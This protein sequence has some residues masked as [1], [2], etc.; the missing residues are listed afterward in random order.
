MNPSFT[1]IQ[2]FQE[3]ASAL[4]ITKAANRLN[5]TQPTL[6]AS[7]KRLEGTLGVDLLVRSKSGVE[8]TKAGAEFQ[9]HSRNLLLQWDQLRANVVNRKEEICGDYIIGAHPSVALF[10]L[11]NFLPE[12]MKDHKDLNI[13]LVHDLSRKITEQTISFKIDF[14]IVVNPIAHPELVIKE[15]CKD[16]VSFWT[17]SKVSSLQKNNGVLIC[18]PELSQSQFLVRSVVKKGIGFSRQIETSNLE[19]IADLV[20]SGAGIGILPSRVAT[21]VPSY[22]LKRASGNWP[23]F[24]DKICLIYRANNQKNLASKAIIHAI[25]SAF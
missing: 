21:R 25:K 13:K 23:V 22:Q 3:V 2:Y 20:H 24:K 19:V 15:L 1:D 14:G 5:V 7:V 4:N 11:S 17:A 18:D 12:L 6:S 10:S 16:E 8:L 9:A